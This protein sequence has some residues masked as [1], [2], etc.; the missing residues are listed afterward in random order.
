[1]FC[2][3]S[4]MPSR[5]SKQRCVSRACIFVVGLPAKPAGG[6]ACLGPGG[7]FRWKSRGR[8]LGR[9]PK[10]PLLGRGANAHVTKAPQT[11]GSSSNSGPPALG[12]AHKD[13]ASF[14]RTVP[15]F[16]APRPLA[17]TGAK[18]SRIHTR[19]IQRPITQYDKY[20][21]RLRLL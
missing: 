13:D 19:D 14:V 6:L 3:A 15:A 20:G 9:G 2:P 1:M 16:A 8:L 18:P 21:N 7:G 12:C 5:S 11:C 4:E 17:G 10:F